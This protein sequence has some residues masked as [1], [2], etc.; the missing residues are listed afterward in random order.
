MCSLAGDL[1]VPQIVDG[2]KGCHMMLAKT[3]IRSPVAGASGYLTKMRAP[4]TR[5]QLNLQARRRQVFVRRRTSR[6]WRSCS[7]VPPV[8]RAERA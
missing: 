6:V 5:P 4:A 2:N 3:H 1:R 8:S 7:I